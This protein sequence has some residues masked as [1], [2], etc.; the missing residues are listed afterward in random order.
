MQFFLT[1]L[2]TVCLS[3]RPGESMSCQVWKDNVPASPG[4]TCQLGK[5]DCEAFCCFSSKYVR[6]VLICL[7]CMENAKTV[8]AQL[9]KPASVG[10]HIRK[11]CNT[12]IPRGYCLEVLRYAS[13]RGPRAILRPASRSPSQHPSQRVLF[14]FTQANSWIIF[15]LLFKTTA[16]EAG[17]DK[18]T[19]FSGWPWRSHKSL[20]GS[21]GYL[22]STSSDF[23]SIS[24]D[25]FSHCWHLQNHFTI[26]M[27]TLNCIVLEVW[28]R[29]A[30]NTFL[31]VFCGRTFLCF[32][33]FNAFAVV[34]FLVVSLEVTNIQTSV[35]LPNFRFPLRSPKSALS[36]RTRWVH[37]IQ[38]RCEIVLSVPF[39][40]PISPSRQ[41]FP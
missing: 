34:S 29:L 11:I 10:A 14:C 41:K 30:C 16:G 26:S 15:H 19:E 6:V 2:G 9:E 31:L 33:F 22:V 23:K 3:Q 12:C 24:R 5:F 28:R 17:N 40:Y 38:T 39:G 37:V 36:V 18:D 21:V 1:S 32:L 13:L 4:S 25:N 8:T 35:R 7:V 20:P 27:G